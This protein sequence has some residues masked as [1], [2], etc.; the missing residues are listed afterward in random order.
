M[1]YVTWCNNWVGSSEVFL[2][3]CHTAAAA[4]D[5]LLLTVVVAVLVVAV[6]VV[7]L[8]VAV[9]VVVLVPSALLFLS[10]SVS[11]LVIVVFVLIEVIEVVDVILENY[12][13]GCFYVLP[14]ESFAQKIL[15]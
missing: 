15:C 3:L 2:P 7:A 9:V 10:L 4:Q 12:F 5:I 13:R 8:A 6:A 14:S 1:L 11:D